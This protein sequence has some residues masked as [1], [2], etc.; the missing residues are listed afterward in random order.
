MF[1]SGDVAERAIR[2]VPRRRFGSVP[3]SLS[4]DTRCFG[5]SLPGELSDS[6]ELLVGKRDRGAMAGELSKGKSGPVASKLRRATLRWYTSAGE[7]CMAGSAE[8]LS[9]LVRSEEEESVTVAQLS[10]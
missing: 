6:R 3:L 2:H 1:V 8:S 5:V 7:D 9:E 10:R 4:K